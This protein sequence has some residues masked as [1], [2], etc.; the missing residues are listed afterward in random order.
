[1]AYMSPEQARG[2]PLD[3]RT[4]L[5]SFGALL[6]EMA[7]GRLPFE[8][9]TSAVLFDAI[10]NREPVAPPRLNPD[11]PADLDRIIAKNLLKNA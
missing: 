5:F 8:G 10:L 11:L 3:A 4:D 7:T 6:Y 2:L 1:M 9:T